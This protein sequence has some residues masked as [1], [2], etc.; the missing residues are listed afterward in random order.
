MGIFLFLLLNVF[1]RAEI[2]AWN[3]TH[4]AWT[5]A[6][7]KKFSEFISIL[8]ASN[9]RSLQAC[10]TSVE[11][12]PFYASRTPV[13][14]G[15][16]ADCAD[17]PYMLRAYFAWMEEL[18]LSYVSEVTFADPLDGAAD[19]RY[20]P[21]GNK[22]VAWRKFTLG[23]KYNVSK[24]LQILRDAVS[25]ATYRMAY[26]FVSDFYPVKISPAFI[27]PGTVVYDPSG[28]AAMVFKVEKDGRV[29]MIDAHPDQSITRITY[30]RKFVRSRPEH[31]AGFMVD[32]KQVNYYDYVR[33]QMAG[34][35][36]KYD[37]VS[38]LKSMLSELCVNL[39]D[40]VGAVSVAVN[41][42]I[43][44]KD[45]PAVLPNNIYGTSGEWESF[46]TPSRDARLKVAFLE[47]RENTETY[48]NRFRAGD[49]KIDYK[50]VGSR[51]SSACGSDANCLLAASLLTAYED[52]A[53]SPA[54]QITYNNSAGGAVTLGYHEIAS[55][56]F[57][58]SFDP[59]HC[60]ELRWGASSPDELRQCGNSQDKLNW[61]SAEQNL[62]NQL[63]RRY[64]LFMGYDAA[65]TK[66]KLGVKQAPDVD[67]EGFL[68]GLLRH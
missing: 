44:R 56:L 67:L 4:S 60:V 52:A 57:K 10:L 17:L 50:P 9:C 32:G 18:P 25:T 21:H 13:G 29:R 1:A 15:Y 66:A 58:L 45:H 20:T 16:L 68:R 31:G 38:E 51:H 34:G 14:I 2:P 28:H 11:S 46:S 37:P 35:N 63:E 33:N 59:Y 26:S 3:I 42:G 36:L 6:N 55:R 22:P 47:L 53:G 40:R 5:S 27:Q 65:N 12:N 23:K 24:E 49:P 30:D 54:C 8:G 19:I 64:D 7:E 48:I 41:A 39:Q 62:R 43:D 61:F